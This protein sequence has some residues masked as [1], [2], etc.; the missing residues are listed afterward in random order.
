ME[1]K[2]KKKKISLSE[3]QIKSISPICQFGTYI[4]C[5]LCPI[6]GRSEIFPNDS[7]DLLTRTVGLN[8]SQLMGD[9]DTTIKL[10]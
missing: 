6:A 9:F 1:I 8:K 5:Q 7:N 4:I 3:L 2:D 10:N